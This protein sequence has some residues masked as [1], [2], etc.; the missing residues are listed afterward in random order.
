MP[1]RVVVVLDGADGLAQRTVETLLADGIDALALPSFMV[2]LDALE[3]SQRIE[4]LVTCP[5]FVAG[6][7]NGIALARMARLKRPGVKILFIGSLEFAHLADG[8]G[9]FL[10][11]PTSVDDV[12]GVVTR[13]LMK[14]AAD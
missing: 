11:T 6:P 5:E 8:L 3:A 13:M 2:A 14:A 1:A 9:E 4:L 7:P 12:T 10:P